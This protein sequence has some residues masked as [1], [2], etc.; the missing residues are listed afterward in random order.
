MH[1]EPAVFPPPPDGEVELVCHGM[2]DIHVHAGQGAV[3]GIEDVR[4]EAEDGDDDN[5]VTGEN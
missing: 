5:T 4:R 3:R 1:R 2:N